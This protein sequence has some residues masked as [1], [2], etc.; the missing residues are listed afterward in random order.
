MKNK[1]IFKRRE[2]L[3]GVSTFG[4]IGL[5]A[6]C[7]D[8]KIE[9]GTP[10]KPKK[11]TNISKN[12]IQWRMATTWPKNFPGVGTTAENVAKDIT[13]AS[14]GRLEIKVYGS[15][16]IVPAYEVFE[17]VRQNT[18]EIGH[19][20]SGYWISKHPGLAYFGGIPGGLSPSEQS[21]WI[22]QGGGQKLWEEILKPYGI[23][24]FQAGIVQTEMFGWY[25][26]ALNSLEDIKGLKIRM[27]G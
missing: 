11:A 9:G 14:G 10:A 22:L 8:N 2:I 13:N 15:G 1:N 18:V 5:L 20:W 16:E 21:A 7:K 19:G 25:K 23:Q 24:P 4:A 3:V 26:N 17:A 12:I 27:A 6:S